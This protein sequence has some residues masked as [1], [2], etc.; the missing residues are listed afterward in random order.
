MNLTFNESEKEQLA[1]L[2]NSPLLHRGIQLA[3]METGRQK[4]G[5]ETIEQSALAFHY[6]EGARNV[7][8]TLFGYADIKAS[9]QVLPKR[10]IHRL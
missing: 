1:H 3:L 6:Q 2:L 5:S 4:S 9:P 10:L 8:G 7:I